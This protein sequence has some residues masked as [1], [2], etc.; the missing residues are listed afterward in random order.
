MNDSPER[1]PLADTA[2]QDGLLTVYLNAA[3]TS[4]SNIE[5]RLG[6]EPFDFR[7][8]LSFWHR[9]NGKITESDSRP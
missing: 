3:K 7:S 2:L 9:Q 8:L 6:R 4:D 1:P 5:Q